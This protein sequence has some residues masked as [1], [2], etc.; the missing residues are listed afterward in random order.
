[1]RYYRLSLD[2]QLRYDEDGHGVRVH[3]FVGEDG[4][5][6]WFT[7]DELRAMEGVGRWYPAQ[8]HN[9]YEDMSVAA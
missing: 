1:M 4:V 7:D 2:S 9:V 5:Q 6:R 3:A 8:G